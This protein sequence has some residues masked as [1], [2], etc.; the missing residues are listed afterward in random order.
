MIPFNR[1]VWKNQISGSLARLVIIHISAQ[2]I[3]IQVRYNIKIHIL[4]T[5]VSLSVNNLTRTFLTFI[6][7]YVTTC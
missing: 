6:I 3:G 2:R 1:E 4:P 7:S 5:Y